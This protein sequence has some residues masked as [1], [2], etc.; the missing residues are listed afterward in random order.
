MTRL[1]RFAIVAIALIAAIESGHA[2]FAGNGQNFTFTEQVIIER[3]QL[4]HELVAIDPQ[5]VRKL[6]D[7]VAAAKQTR[8]KSAVKMKR[9]RDVRNN[10]NTGDDVMTVNPKQNPDLYLLFQRSSP[11]AAYDLFQILKQ[12]SKHSAVN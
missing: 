5:G 4:L 8:R 1:I 11:E 9:N 6:I 12:V 2:D 3:N 7:A 10:R